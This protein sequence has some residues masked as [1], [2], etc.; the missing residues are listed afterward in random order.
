VL[1]FNDWSQW[2]PL[3]TVAGFETKTVFDLIDFLT[4]N[5]MLTLGG[6]FIS[7]FVGWTMSS[8]SVAEELGGA[9]SGHQAFRFLLRYVCP[10]AVFAVFVAGVWGI[11]GG[12]G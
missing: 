4:S 10:L 8:A 5:I 3:A 11:G 1:S 12:G 2:F 6:V 7:L 9:G